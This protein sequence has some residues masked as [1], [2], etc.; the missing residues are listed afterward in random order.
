MFPRAFNFDNTMVTVELRELVKSIDIWDFDYPSFYQG[1]EKTAFEQ[2]V[3]DHYA[4]RQIGMETPGRWL[5]YFRSRIREIMPYYIQLYKSVELMEKQEDPLESYHLTETYES[6]TKSSGTSETGSETG[7]E[8]VEM[9]SNTPQ[10][11]ISNLD[12][13]LTEA[14]K[15]DGKVTDKTNATSTGDSDTSYTMTRRG[16]IGVQPLGQEIKIYRDSLI[17]VDMMIIDELKDLFLM[18][19]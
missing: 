8:K 1:E 11:E 5:H 12:K 18:T 16:N 10:G 4:L 14:T 13:Y 15:N 17:N 19:Y 7:S 9:F 3:I 6:K 2:K